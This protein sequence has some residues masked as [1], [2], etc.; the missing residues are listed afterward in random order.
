MS[1]DEQRGD[2]PATDDES[3]L[4]TAVGGQVLPSPASKQIRFSIKVLALPNKVKG[5]ALDIDNFA[6]Y[7]ELTKNILECRSSKVTIYLDMTDIQK[8]WSACGSASGEENHSEDPSL[9]TGLSALDLEFARIR[10]KL[11]KKYQNDHDSG[12]TY[13]GWDETYPLTPL[14]MLEWAHTIYDGEVTTRDPPN[15]A[16]GTFDPAN[17]KVSLHPSRASL[18]TSM[19]P[20]APSGSDLG[21]LATIVTALIGNRH[22]TTPAPPLMPT[23]HHLDNLSIS[24]GPLAVLSPPFPTPSKLKHFLQHAEQNSGSKMPSHMMLTG[25]GIRTGDVIQLKAGAEQ[26]WKGPDAKR[27]CTDSESDVGALSGVPADKKVS[28]EYR[29]PSG[30]MMRFYGPR[31]KPGEAS[32]QDRNTF[33]RCEARNDWYP[34]PLGFVPAMAEDPADKDDDPFA[35]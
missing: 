30:G 2:T 12:Y 7:E 23:N 9:D 3:I 15:L 32:T 24:M 27:K 17:R 26:W 14:M 34:I 18:N 22:P 21:H 33:Y 19:A 4:V 29:S 28:F 35:E 16:G 5:D 25:L 10:G 6:D 13:V 11:E 1:D 31:M 8:A 20:V